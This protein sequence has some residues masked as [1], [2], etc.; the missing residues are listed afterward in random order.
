[1][2]LAELKSQYTDTPEF[3]K[4]VHDLFT[5]LVDKDDELRIHRDW[6][7]TAIWGFGEKSFWWMWMLLLA[8]LP[9]TPSLLEIG[10]F[11]AA[12]LSLW[13][14]L[15]PDAHVFGITP[16]DSSGGVWESDYA[17][18]I[19][20][21][22][23]K[24]NLPQPFIYKG[25][26]DNGDIVNTASNFKYDV[27]YVDGDHSFEGALFDLNTYSPLVKVGGYLVIDDCC[28]DLHMQFGYFQGIQSVNDAFSEWKK[29]EISKSF[30][31][32]FN[33][34]HLRCLKR[35]K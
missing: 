29:K 14:M 27:V 11:R 28:C 33:V 15:K 12:T 1:M 6:V 25:R 10:V 19:K 26:S 31:F 4:R 30:E 2:T 23:D 5:Q 18:D 13:K 7:Q 24:F 35:V 34:V 22:H 3:H 9:E 8:E 21:I 17:A 16:L 20:Q 32:Q